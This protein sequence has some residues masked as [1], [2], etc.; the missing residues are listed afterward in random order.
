VQKWT[1]RPPLEMDVLLKMPT[2]PVN[3]DHI[4]GSG[5]VGRMIAISANVYADGF[6]DQEEVRRFYKVKKGNG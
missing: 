4:Y 6:I 5:H 2:M 1:T 3:M